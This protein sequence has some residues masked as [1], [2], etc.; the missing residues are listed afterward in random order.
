MRTFACPHLLLGEA[1]R[2]KDFEVMIYTQY[3]K[4]NQQKS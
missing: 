2:E 1:S 4:Q 3:S